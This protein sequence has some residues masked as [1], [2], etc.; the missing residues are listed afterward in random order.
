VGL[1]R[2]GAPGTRREPHVEDDDG[3]SAPARGP[4]ELH[5]GA[6][7]GHHDVGLAIRSPNGLATGFSV[8]LEGAGEDRSDLCF[9]FLAPVNGAMELNYPTDVHSKRLAN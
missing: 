6:L 3:A 1:A 7:P 9:V 4:E 2:V 8:H 5:E